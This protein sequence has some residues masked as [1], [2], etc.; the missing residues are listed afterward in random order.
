M[1]HNM[2]VR[3]KQ[4]WNTH[5]SVED[6]WVRLILEN[7][8]DGRGREACMQIVRRR[9]KMH[10]MCASCMGATDKVSHPLI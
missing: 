9:A 10:C 3:V 5:L 6:A 4:E 2:L 1:F 7:W 8:V